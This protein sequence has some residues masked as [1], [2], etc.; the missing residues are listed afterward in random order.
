MLSRLTK[1]TLQNRALFH[2]VRPFA[3]VTKYTKSHEWIRFDT[4]TGLARV[5]ITNH[6]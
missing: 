4:E 6:A 3:L 5:G 2:P 1:L